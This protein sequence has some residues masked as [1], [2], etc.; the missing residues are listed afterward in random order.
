MTSSSLSTLSLTPEQ[1][2]AVAS[3]LAAVV[4][5]AATRPFHW[6]YDLEELKRVIGDED[7]EFWPESKSPFYT[8]PTGESMKCNP[9]LSYDK[10]G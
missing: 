9:K 6:L 4:A 7:P 5:D 2:S 3:I 1:D 8:L 10:F